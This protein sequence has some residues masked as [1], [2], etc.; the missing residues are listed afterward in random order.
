MSRRTKSKEE[1]Y[2]EVSE[3]IEKKKKV[4]QKLNPVLSFLK[5]NTSPVVTILGLPTDLMSTG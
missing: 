5:S 4:I 3:N 2:E 1:F